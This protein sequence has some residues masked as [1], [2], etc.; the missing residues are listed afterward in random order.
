MQNLQSDSLEFLINSCFTKK[1]K[2]HV[3]FR[4]KAASIQRNEGNSTESLLP[5]APTPGSSDSP[6]DSPQMNADTVVKFC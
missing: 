2:S 5:T 3:Q 4:N 6:T 1:K